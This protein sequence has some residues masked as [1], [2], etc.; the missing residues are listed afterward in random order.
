MGLMYFLR[1]KLLAITTLLLTLSTAVSV[2][3]AL[4]PYWFTLTV[5]AQYG[6][7]LD[8]HSM[9][10]RNKYT[11]DVGLFFMLNDQ[12]LGGSR[13]INMLMQDKAYNET[14]APRKY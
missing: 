4:A 6:A 13:Y 7:K 8:A 3:A 1:A 12:R 11:L 2:L 14:L 9:S 5:Q 10:F